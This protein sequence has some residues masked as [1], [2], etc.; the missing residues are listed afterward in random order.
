MHCW[1]LLRVIDLIACEDYLYHCSGGKEIGNDVINGG[2]MELTWWNI[3]IYSA[4]FN[5]HYI[6]KVL[7]RKVVP[8]MK[9]KRRIKKSG[10]YSVQFWWKG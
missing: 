6:Y 4:V 8:I 3:Y 7:V 10:D 1:S 2:V 5:S 9:Y